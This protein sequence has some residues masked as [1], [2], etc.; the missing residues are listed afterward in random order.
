[1]AEFEE[2]ADQLSLQIIDETL[3]DG[4]IFKTA[5][6]KLLGPGAKLLVG[7]RGTGKTHVMRYTYLHAMKTPSAPLV[8]IPVIVNTDS[9]RS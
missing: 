1:M 5:R 4:G 2:R 7:P 9:G 8:R 3:A 6:Q